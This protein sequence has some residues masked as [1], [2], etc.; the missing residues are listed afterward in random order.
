MVLKVR[1]LFEIL[2]LG[3][4]GRSGSSE[5]EGGERYF[6]GQLPKHLIFTIIFTIILVM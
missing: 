1:C 2:R 4:R 3:T 5:M 6:S